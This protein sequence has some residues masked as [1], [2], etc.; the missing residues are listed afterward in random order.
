MTASVTFSPRYASAS[1][2]SFWRTIALI[3]VGELHEDAV[4]LGILDDL[5]GHQPLAPLHLRVIPSAAH[6]AL[7]RVHGVRRVRDRLALGQLPDEPLAGLA[8]RHDRRD[9]ASA[10]GRGDDGG[11][12]ALH[13]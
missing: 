12:A 4:R 7:D 9:R 5:V 11:L 3:S 13:G 6:E 2:L 8:E 1:A 10:L